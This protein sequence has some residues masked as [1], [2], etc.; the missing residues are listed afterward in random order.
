MVFLETCTSLK[1][2]VNKMTAVGVKITGD[3]MKKRTKADSSYQKR[4]PGSGSTNCCTLIFLKMEIV[5]TIA[6]Q[7]ENHTSSR[8]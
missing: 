2:H 5:N 7:H 4:P 3:L 1:R 6:L 8:W